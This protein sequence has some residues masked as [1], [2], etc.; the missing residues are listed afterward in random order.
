MSRPFAVSG[1][2]LNIVIEGLEYLD[3]GFS[4]VDRDLRLLACNQRMLQ[5]LDLPPALGAAGTSMEALFRYNAERGEYGPGDTDELIEER[6]ALARRFEPHCFERERMDGSVLE[7]RGNPLPDGGFI[8]TYTDITERRRA[9]DEKQANL[10]FLQSMDLANRAIAGSKE[11][12]QVMSD[13][14]D[15]VL[16]VL[17]CDRAY[18]LHPCD[19]G[20]RSWNVPMERARQE[21]PRL[22]AGGVDVSVDAEVSRTFRIL[23]DADGPVQFGTGDRH[24]IPAEVSERFGVKSSMAMALHPK[25]DQPWQFGIHQCSRY[26]EWSPDEERLFQEIGLRLTD[27]L[28]GLLAFRS[29]RENERRLQQAERIARVGYWDRDLLAGRVNLSEE[30]R[31][32]FG[33]TPEHQVSD[34]AYWHELWRQRI[35][36]SDRER[37]ARAAAEA[38]EEDIP[39]DVEYR[40]VQPGGG[41]C[42][43]KSK[44]EVTR[45]DSGRPVRMF[46]TMQDITE[47][48]Q[49]ERTLRRLNQDL[50]QTNRLLAAIIEATPVAIIG[51]DLEGRIH[52]VWN[53]AAEKMLGWSADEV[54]GQVMPTVSTENQEE[55]KQYLDMIRDGKSIH[56]V[57]VLRHRRDGTPIFYGIYASPLRDAENRITGNI[58][59]LV[60]YTQR[61]LADEA[62]RKSEEKYRRIV[63]TAN[64]GIWL[65][66][67]DAVTSFVNARMAE[68]LG[69]APEEMAGRALYEF[70]FEEDAPE[71]DQLMENRRPEKLKG[72]ELRFRCRDGQ[73]LW[74]LASIAHVFDDDQQFKGAFGMFTD[75]TER[76][77]Q[78]EQLL[79]Q[80]H[81]DALTGLPNRF[82]CLDRLEQSVK[83]ARRHGWRS[84]LLFLDLDDFK[85]VN[86]ALGHEVGDRVLV[87][88]AAR[89]R[90]AVREEDTVGRLGGDEFVVLIGN[91]VEP[92]DVCPVA[93]KI[94]QAFQQVFPVMGR[95][96]MLTASLGVAIYPDDGENPAVLLRNADTAMYYTKTRGGDT[97]HFFTES[98]NQNVSR[99]LQ[100][101]EQ[102]RFALERN[103]LY[104][105]YQ[106][107]VAVASGAVVGAEVLLR[108]ENAMLGNVEPQEFVDV[109]ERS[110]LIIAI[111]DWVIATG[112]QQLV[113]WQRLGFKGFRLALNVSPRQ[114]REA[115]FAAS[116]RRRIDDLGLAGTSLDLEV[117]E[118]VLLSGE[119]GAA[120]A[121]RQVRRLGVGVAMD[122]FGTGYSSLSYLRNFS[123]DSLKIDR[124]FIRDLTDDP[125]DRELV[126]SCIRIAKGLGLTAVAEGVETADQLEFLRRVSCDFAQ[127]YL[128]SAPLSP[129]D[130]TEIIKQ[131]AL[132]PAGPDNAGQTVG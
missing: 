52:S 6:L 42:E 55:F 125:H 40:V 72:I 57:E 31:R 7:I 26:K 48:K 60:D 3:Q 70:L 96:V 84:A 38:L 81:Y 87:S 102:L 82:L 130:M 107:I 58:A 59:V 44:G 9:E 64:E 111:G 17:D 35:H 90:E 21:H 99:R 24:P 12:E 85:K 11:L 33:L 79:Y 92:A 95:H 66:G 78:Q 29:L 32:V 109:A 8:T 54:M 83:A 113:D 88:A 50:Q 28:T 105:V 101:E 4:I 119:H 116:L 67:A 73:Q 16:S 23:L 37:V 61:K 126:V 62:L 22:L 5:L 97:Y 30:T 47:Q 115:G 89:L 91:I 114:F 65:L 45:D 14:L 127:G 51:L 93:E 112:L 49:V 71:F 123:F 19:P 120:R 75:I 25:V 69:Y 39:Y 129:G 106:P 132:P 100:L 1:K 2:D 36:S 108:W 94:V 74:T 104:L 103:E 43:V 13:V 118:G 46:G 27:A 41:V 76:K 10:H 80:A 63:D 86:D 53:P 121:L 124:S 117:T 18:L 68:M 128:F 34:L 98:M 56:G 77:R 122:D 15:V 20:A 110:G 131:G